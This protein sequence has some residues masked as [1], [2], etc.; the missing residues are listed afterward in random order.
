MPRSEQ[1]TVTQ[2]GTIS[3]RGIRRVVDLG[4]SAGVDRDLLTSVGGIR[5][6]DARDPDA[7]VPVT[8]EIAVW[9]VIA[10][11]VSD[12]G[13]GIARGAAMRI[14]EG[15]LLGYVIG[16][17][18]TL[19]HSLRALARYIHIFS[20][21]VDVRLDDAATSVTVVG[22][23]S[24]GL[25]EP[26]AQTYRIATVLQCMREVTGVDVIPAEV[27]FTYPQPSG[28]LA[29]REFF[30]CPIRFR[31]DDAGMTFRQ[32]DLHLPTVKADAVLAGYL[33][34]YADQVLASLVR[35]ETLRHRVRALIWSQSAAGNAT[36]QT[37][38]SAL[39]MSA[40]TLQRQL[41]AEGTSLQ[42]EL[43]DVRKTVSIA[44]LRNPDVAVDDVAFLLGYAEP[45]AFYR[46]FKRWTGQTP[47]EF[48]RRAA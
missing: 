25:A 5:D 39:G 42:Q 31:A 17:T 37:V 12:T 10:R 7:R 35:G 40:R 2:L 4:V 18:P 15:G 33:G 9:Q 21:A 43:Q 8:A 23:P 29:H 41:R 19:H 14:R 30:R 47:Q 28:I 6:L 46:S 24:L 34:K 48:R 11:Y 20:E 27:R 44:A 13:V 22:H 32:S 1:R 36:L 16:F 38:A 26:L 3:A 45:S